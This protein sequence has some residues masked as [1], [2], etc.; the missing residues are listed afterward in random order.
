M[1]LLL[2]CDLTVSVGY[3]NGIIF[4]A[5]IVHVNKALLFPEKGTG[6]LILTTF[7]AWINLDLGIETCF[8]KNMD[9]YSKVL[10]QF[11]FPVYLWVMI[12]FIV[13]LAH[14]SSRAGRLIGSNSVP[15]LATLFLLSYAKLLRTIITAV[16][17]TYIEFE[18]GTR[19]TVWLEDGNIQYFSPKHTVLFFVA[20]LFF[21]LYIFPLTL[22][23]LFAPCLQS[24][25]HHKPFRW[26]NKIK[27]FVD[28]YQG[29]YSNKFRFWTGLLLVIRVVL[30]VIFALNFEKDPSMNYF[31]TVIIIGPIAMF[32]FTK[33]NVYRHKIVNLTESVSLLN[34]TV[35][36]IVSWICTATSY[37][38]WHSIRKYVT[39]VS[40]ALLLLL[41]LIILLNKENKFFKFIKKLIRKRRTD[42]MAA[43]DDCIA[44]P[45]RNT[46]T[47]TFS[48]VEIDQN[49]E[50]PLI[51]S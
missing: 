25:S 28:A 3:I 35:L 5:N 21:L 14:Y 7:V 2:K 46:N 24:Q 49:L 39:Y 27:P 50:E 30:L 11:V 43:N 16:S 10:L 13:F 48:L 26:I 42:N 33:Q 17:F 12:G 38:E 36:F 47:P 29:P 9:T 32:C 23:T 34:I 37:T 41:S 40:I 6:Y 31:W 19:V 51:Q 1:I 15:V 18:D 20:L 4:Y 8:I 44:Q 22:L 45:K